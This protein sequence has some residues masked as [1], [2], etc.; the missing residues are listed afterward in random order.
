MKANY[1]VMNKTQAR[2]IAKEEVSKLYEEVFSECAENVMQQ[3][4]SNVLLCLERDYGWRSK[5]LREFVQNLRGWCDIMQQDT[6][7]TKSWT[8]LD[9]IA[10]FL[11]KYNI[12][13]KKEF[14]AEVID[15]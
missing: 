14:Q 7:I 4:V 13:I 9:N 3:V 10:Y 6:P 15:P 11:E 12:D 5:R 1:G 2:K 8:T